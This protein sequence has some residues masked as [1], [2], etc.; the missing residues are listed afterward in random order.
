MK[1][2]MY[3]FVISRLHGF[4]LLVRTNYSKL[5]IAVVFSFA[6]LACGIQS[7]AGRRDDY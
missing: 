6:M 5:K 3:G 2:I 4:V 1:S 7:H